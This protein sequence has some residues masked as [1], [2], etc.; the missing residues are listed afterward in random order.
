MSLIGR[1]LITWSSATDRVLKD[2][3]TFGRWCLAGGSGSFGGGSRLWGLQPGPT[4]WQVYF[5][6]HTDVSKQHSIPTTVTCLSCCQ[7]LPGLMAAIKQWGQWNLSSFQCFF[8]SVWPQRWGNLANTDTVYIPFKASTFVKHRSS[9]TIM[10]SS[11]DF[12]CYK[13][14]LGS[15]NCLSEAL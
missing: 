3:R 5:L 13:N 15:Y 2:Y 4:S 9:T 11:T 14:D 7:S 6:I 1:G 10:K 8:S 12:L